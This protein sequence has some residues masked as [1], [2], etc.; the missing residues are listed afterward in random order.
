MDIWPLSPGQDKVDVAKGFDTLERGSSH[1]PFA[2]SDKIASWGRTICDPGTGRKLAEIAGSGNHAI[3]GTKLVVAADAAADRLRGRTR[4][5]RM[6]LKQFWVYDVADPARPKLLSEGNLI[7][8]PETPTD[9]A[10]TYFPEFHK[11]QLKK[12]GLGC[13][14]GIGAGFGGA[15]TSAVTAHG[16]RIYI[17]SNTHLYCIGE[18]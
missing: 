1:G 12:F 9:I 17:K 7:G 8:G 4:D 2:L 11:P 10:D 18:R 5:D 16:G 13:Y 6:C 14:H 15:E 3:C